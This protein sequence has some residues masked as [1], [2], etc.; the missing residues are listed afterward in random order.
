MINILSNTLGNWKTFKEP[1]GKSLGTH[2]EQTPQKKI[3]LSN[4]KPKKKKSPPEA[5]QLAA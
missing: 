5:S 1:N 3:A 2:W 4:P